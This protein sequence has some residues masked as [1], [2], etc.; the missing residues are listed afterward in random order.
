MDILSEVEGY[1]SE[2][3]KKYGPIPAGV[4][5]NSEESQKIRFDQLLKII[6]T[7]ENFSVLDFGCGYSSLYPYMKSKYGKFHY[8]GFDISHQ[9][10]KEAKRMTK[11]EPVK[12]YTDLKSLIPQEFTIA[13]GIFNV[14]QRTT[15]QEWMKYVLETLSQINLLSLKGFS[16]NMLTSYS[17]EDRKKDYLFYPNPG[18][19]FDLCK[20]ISKEV[21]LLHDYKLYEFT[22]LVRK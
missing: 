21:A 7:F 2:K 8:E 1:Y 3:I 9:M 17:D 12:F 20:K 4:D 18:E 11:G 22:I 10:I 19:V 15:S 16:F 14:K 13:S 5:W 6:P